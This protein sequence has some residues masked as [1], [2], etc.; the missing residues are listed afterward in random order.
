MVKLKESPKEV[1]EP[2]EKIITRGN[3]I[4]RHLDAYLA[5]Y[6]KIEALNIKRFSL[7]PLLSFEHFKDNISRVLS[8][9]L[10]VL[11]GGSIAI[12]APFGRVSGHIM[13]DA[14]IA[15]AASFG[16][17]FASL[18]AFEV[19]DYFS[20][21]SHKDISEHGRKRG[22]RIAH[23]QDQEK[24][25][26]TEK[27]LRMEM[28]QLQLDI[29][30]TQ[31]LI[32]DT[33][34]SPHRD[35]V[36][37]S[38][39]EEIDSEIGRKDWKS[40][41]IQ[42]LVVIQ[43]YLGQL[44]PQQEALL[45]KTK[46][47][48]SLALLHEDQRYKKMFGTVGVVG[49]LLGSESMT[50]Y[51]SRGLEHAA[52]KM[53]DFFDIFAKSV[54]DTHT[55]HRFLSPALSSLSGT[56]FALTSGILKMMRDEDQSKERNEMVRQRVQEMERSVAKMKS[57]RSE[58][59]AAL[60]EYFPA[61]APPPFLADAVPTHVTPQ[62]D[63]FQQ[64]QE[65]FHRVIAGVEG[66]VHGFF[67]MPD[68]K[69]IFVP[70][71]QIS[72]EEE[73]I[74]ESV[75]S[76]GVPSTGPS[77]EAPTLET[78]LE[79][80]S[81]FIRPLTFTE[82]EHQK[83]ITFKPFMLGL[84]RKNALGDP[85]APVDDLTNKSEIRDVL[86][87]KGEG[88]TLNVYDPQ[89]GK[90]LPKPGVERLIEYLKGHTDAIREHYNTNDTKTINKH[91]GVE[92]TDELPTL[93]ETLEAVQRNRQIEEGKEFILTHSAQQLRAYIIREFHLARLS[94]QEMEQ[95]DQLTFE[96]VLAHW[97]SKDTTRERDK[98]ALERF[99]TRFNTALIGLEEEGRER[100]IRDRGAIVEVIHGATQRLNRPS[101][102]SIPGPE[103]K[104]LR[105][106]TERVVRTYNLN[107]LGLVFKE[108]GTRE[109]IKKRLEQVKARH[110]ITPVSDIITGHG[111]TEITQIRYHQEGVESQVI[112]HR[113]RAVETRLIIG[114]SIQRESLILPGMD[115]E[116]LSR[117][118]KIVRTPSRD[119]FH[120]L[121]FD[122]TH[123]DL[124]RAKFWK[125][126]GPCG[127]MY[128]IDDRGAD[129]VAA[130]QVA[131]LPYVIGKVREVRQG[132]EGAGF[133]F[134][135][136]DSK[137]DAPRFHLVRALEHMRLIEGN[138][139]DTIDFNGEG[140]KIV[141]EIKKQALPWLL[142]FFPSLP[143]VTNAYAN[144]YP[145][146]F[147]EL[148]DLDGKPVSPSVIELLGDEKKFYDRFI[149][150]Q[151]EQLLKSE[152]KTG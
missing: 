64:L 144:L 132:G 15:I 138:I 122:P 3:R 130:A 9:V 150:F 35:F 98:K 16:T 151:R 4:S 57:L 23:T 102:I 28:A 72:D 59:G 92:F 77:E 110:F 1:R 24:E 142:W 105:A 94:D 13:D 71:Q 49:V 140:K 91:F 146:F 33:V 60:R 134:T 96:S 116:I 95:M 106:D 129:I 53:R 67:A 114:F 147:S 41:E 58:V 50:E 83:H 127:D 75:D 43:H 17:W 56:L 81:E 62:E 42:Q 124:E 32:E 55:V 93:L 25:K 139:P 61:S 143:K 149:Q 70:A 79:V 137:Y 27:S 113:T 54:V 31:R 12:A 103:Q 90:P 38:T 7:A 85:G 20:P 44:I 84:L 48:E 104:Q 6:D 148:K 21:V 119:V 8:S 117:V 141:F 80:G 51:F 107:E 120:H 87:V 133:V 37:Q 73:Q 128:F 14:A 136:S 10:Q 109:E 121:F 101:E 29:F 118:E 78:P 125:F 65:R 135:L 26:S 18:R 66:A 52:A 86:M 152:D 123:G 108:G 63:L 97:H 89:T 34:L 76:S 68:F 47:Y 69:D 40:E 115:D 19:M 2:L 99:L 111:H 131:A 30:A 22:I 112:D 145:K 5:H 74:A 46:E 11:G 36:E 82:L 126:K 39:V 88:L 100:E 45:E